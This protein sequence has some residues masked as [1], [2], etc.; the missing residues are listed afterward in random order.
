MAAGDQGALDRAQPL[1]D[2]MGQRTWRLGEEPRE[3]TAAKLAGNFLIAA[4]IECMG[5]AGV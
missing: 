4:A 1:F 3:A 2:A 5:E